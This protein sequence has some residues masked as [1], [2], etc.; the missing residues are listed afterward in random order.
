MIQTSLIPQQSPGPDPANTFNSPVEVQQQ[1][2]LSSLQHSLF[3]QQ[4]LAQPQSLLNLQSQTNLIQQPQTVLQP[5]Q[6]FQS[7]APPLLQNQNGFQM[8]ASTAPNA[9]NQAFYAALQAALIQQNPQS[10]FIFYF[11]F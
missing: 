11:I 2:A 5:Q 7:L 6:T 4:P 10:H 1:I 8:G 3:Q 9:M